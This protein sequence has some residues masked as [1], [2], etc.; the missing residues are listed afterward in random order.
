MLCLLR[1]RLRVHSPARGKRP[2]VN[3]KN[4]VFFDREGSLLYFI[5]S[6]RPISEDELK[7]LK[8]HHYTAISDKQILID[9]KLQVEVRHTLKRASLE[10]P[11]FVRVTAPV[12]S[13][14]VLDLF[15]LIFNLL[16]CFF[17]FVIF[18]FCVLCL[19]HFVIPASVRGTRG[20]V[21]ARRGG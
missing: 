21:K 16:H 2:G 18:C 1:C 5:F 10:A 6:F 3:L 11:V 19:F 7:H 13:F 20:E 8:D 12:V 4:R 9:Q 15:L 14:Y 17:C